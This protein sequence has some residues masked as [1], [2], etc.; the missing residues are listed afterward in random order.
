MYLQRFFHLQ[1]I[2]PCQC[3]EKKRR[4]KA[5][6]NIPKGLEKHKVKYAE[7]KSKSEKLRGE[8]TLACHNTKLIW[9]ERADHCG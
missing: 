4:D 8:C 6:T 5:K 9:R 1:P 3:I 7:G 2:I